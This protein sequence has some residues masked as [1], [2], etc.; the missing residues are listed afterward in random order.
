MLQKYE[1]NNERVS[2]I[3]SEADY[4]TSERVDGDLKVEID[5]LASLKEIVRKIDINQKWS[6]KKEH[7]ADRI[8]SRAGSASSFNKPKIT[9]QK[10]EKMGSP[11]IHKTALG[12][13]RLKSTSSDENKTEDN[14]DYNKKKSKKK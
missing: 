2:K 11:L 3:S 12:V 9:H 13:K 4:E 6:S 5:E 1:D 7:P 8:I 14:P 10:S